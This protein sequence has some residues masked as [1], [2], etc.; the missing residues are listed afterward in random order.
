MQFSMGRGDGGVDP[1]VF[2]AVEEEIKKLM[3]KK[4]RVKRQKNQ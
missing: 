4:S 3:R 1:K 2:L